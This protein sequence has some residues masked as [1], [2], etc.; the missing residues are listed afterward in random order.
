[1]HQTV[2]QMFAASTTY[3]ICAAHHASHVQILASVPGSFFRVVRTL[4]GYGVIIHTYISTDT[5]TCKLT[6]TVTVTDRRLT[7]AAAVVHRLKP[8]VGNILPNVAIRSN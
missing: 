6:F 8:V 1:M 5:V 3:S 7:F 2:L 4:P